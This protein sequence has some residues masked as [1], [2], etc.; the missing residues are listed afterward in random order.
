MV[1]GNALFYDNDVYAGGVKDAFAD[2]LA[3]YYEAETYKCPS[4]MM[5]RQ[6]NSWVSRVTGNAART[7]KD[8]EECSMALLNAIQF[9]AIWT[10]K[11]ETGEMVFHNANGSTRN[12]K[13]VKKT[14]S[15]I[16]HNEHGYVANIY[17]ANNAFYMR[18][19]IPFDAEDMDVAVS[20]L[21]RVT[22]DPDYRIEQYIP[23]ETLK[24]V[25]PQFEFSHMADIIPLLQGCGVTNIFDKK[26]SDM[27]GVVANANMF[28]SLLRQNCSLRVDE[29]GT[30]IKVTTTGIALPTMGVTPT[31]ELIV[32]TP[33]AFEIGATDTGV[34]IPQGRVNNLQ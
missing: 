34:V 24:V 12:V 30:E 13:S 22:R 17:Y 28:L 8:D 6:V 4:A 10:K 31:D 25:I 29:N 9:N 5:P 21:R 2:A 1:I 19:Y 7:L 26:D 27:H 3:D 11:P 23:W 20:S 14:S 18:L 16:F 33:F 15:D 32:D